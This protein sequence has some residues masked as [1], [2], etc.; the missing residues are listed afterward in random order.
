MGVFQYLALNP[1]G[2]EIAGIIEADSAAAARRKLRDQGLH[3][4]NVGESV[5]RGATAREV[6]FS[7][8]RRRSAAEEVSLITRQLAVLLEA[9]MPIVDALSAVLEQIDAPRLDRVIH[10]VRDS[11]RQGATLGDAL[12][13][14]PTEFT[15]L[16]V[17][18]I[19][20]GESSGALESV[21]FRLADYTENQIRVAKRI[22]SALVYPVV[23][24]VFGLGIVTFLMGFVIP[25]ISQVFLSFGKELPGITTF[26]IKTCN[27]IRDYW[28]VGII[29]MVAL[30]LGLRQYAKTPSGQRRWDRLRLNAPV[31]GDLSRKLSV[32]RFARTLGTLVQGGLPMMAALDIVKRVVQNVVVEDAVDEARKAVRRGQDLATPLKESGLFSPMLVHMVALGERSGQLE[33]MLLRVADASEEEAQTRV[34]TLMT[35]LEPVIIIVMGL[36]VAFLVLAI[37]LPILDMSQGLG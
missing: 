4:V 31:F 7:A 23:M 2:R 37:L 24:C 33:K 35:L 10:E 20:A 6:P 15:G 17:N 9:G 22:K 30:V 27:L 5:A 3:P 19:R 8:L 12:S 36:F 25:K 34:D 1:T 11:V 21:L 26:L 16:Y 13:A 28:W 18:M 29:V 32:S 14:H